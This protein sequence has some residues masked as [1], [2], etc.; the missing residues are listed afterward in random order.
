MTRETLCFYW[1]WQSDI[2]FP[3][4]NPLQ[5][6][7]HVT[8]GWQPIKG[9]VP[10]R[11]AIPLGPDESEAPDVSLV[12]AGVPLILQY[13]EC[14]FTSL[15]RKVSLV[16]TTEGL[17]IVQHQAGRKE[18]RKAVPHFLAGNSVPDHCPGLNVQG[19]WCFISCPLPLLTL[20]NTGS[21]EGKAL[22]C[23][24][25]GPSIDSLVELLGW[26]SN[27]R[28]WLEEPMKPKTV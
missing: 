10:R 26:L 27:A 7:G 28:C 20:L 18:G 15:L 14:Y 13:G 1:L 22:C 12:A 23:T 24:P 5:A 25:G 6:G 4:A 8:K 2:N 3:P 17:E 16:H 21:S 19:G 11:S 9:C